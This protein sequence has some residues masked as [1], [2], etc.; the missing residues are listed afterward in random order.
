MY[1]KS[2]TVTYTAAPS[3]P[4]VATIGNLTPT[5]LVVG[6]INDFSLE[7]TPA[8][9]GLVEGTDYVVDWQSSDP[10]ILELADET[11]EAKAEGQVTVTV[12]VIPDDDATYNEVSK[13]FDV[14]VTK[15]PQVLAFNEVFY[16]S[17]DKCDGTG[18]NDDSWSGSIASNDIGDSPDNSVWT[19]ENAKAASGCIKCGTGSLG[20]SATANLNLDAGSYTLNFK[21]AAWDGSKENTTLSLSATGAT[22]SKS[23]VT[24]EKAK[25]NDYT[26]T[27]TVATAGEVSFKFSTNGGNSRFFL[28]EVIL[29]IN[30]AAATISSAGYATFNSE[31]AVDFMGTGVTVYTATDNGTTVKLTEVTT[32]Q[33]PAGRAVVLYKEGGATVTAPVIEDAAELGANHLHISTGEQPENAYVLANVEGTVGFYLWESSVTLNAGKVYLQGTSGSRQFLPFADATAISDALAEKAA[34]GVV[35]DLQGRRVVK[36]AKG[37]YI[38]NGKKIIVK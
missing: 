16:E 25:F 26:A 15:A 33:V 32:G 27:L 35:Y 23:S 18:G 17:F 12:T 1:I 2:I 38:V 9:T 6:E 21:A 29:I 11:Y 22:L 28:D 37:L 10:T 24:L 5:S 20:G 4:A 34:D 8:T 30:S 19:F 13:T 31:Y 36:A 3:V 14:T 7:I